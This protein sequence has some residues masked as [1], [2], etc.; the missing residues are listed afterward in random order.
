M[1][2]RKSNMELDDFKNRNKTHTTPEI[3][4]EGKNRQTM[5]TFIEELKALDAKERKKAGIMMIIL[6][7]FIAVYSS[8]FTLQKGDMKTGYSLLVLGFIIAIVYAF[9][10]YRRI[11][12]VNY[13]VPT[14]VFLTD[15]E[16]RCRFMTPV[17]WLITIPI[18][19]LFIAGGSV[20]VYS[21]FIRYFGD[22]LVPVFIYLGIMAGAITVGFW[23]SYRNW[24]K[25]KGWM[26]KKVQELKREF[27]I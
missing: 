16:Q 8:S 6:V 23:A 14:T 22:S 10:R 3:T 19:I 18:L 4:G 9:W 21:T 12:D 15:A 2:G 1:N 24:E 5:E 25:D 17:D 20:I 11:K 7:M 26:L 27:G 13:T